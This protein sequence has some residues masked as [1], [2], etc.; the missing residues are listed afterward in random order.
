MEDQGWLV[1]GL[2][3]P[4]SQYRNTWH[5]AGYDV[6][7]EMARRWDI[8]LKPGKSDYFAGEKAIYGCKH[9]FM[10]PTSFM[11]RSGTPV[12]YFVRYFKHP[13]EKVLV[14]LDDHDIMFGKIR[15]REQGSAAGH[16]GLSDII[17]RLN[18]ES[19]HRLR[20][21]IKQ[22]A[23]RRDLARQ[24]LSAIP[25]RLTADYEIVVKNAADAV[26]MALQSGFRKAMNYYNGLEIFNA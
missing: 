12:S 17:L 10:I 11:N 21:G 8:S 26:E 6:I 9:T 13:V 24:V 1:V 7:E 20:I 15:L 16:K 23:E 18:T 5:N 2:G 14:I 4:G 25:K 3:N 22:D 19:I